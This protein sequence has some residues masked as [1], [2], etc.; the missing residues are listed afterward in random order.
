MSW[1]GLTTMNTTPSKEKTTLSSGRYQNLPDR[2]ESETVS[3][4]IFQQ[5]GFEELTEQEGSDLLRL[6]RQVEKAFY[7][8]GKALAEIRERRLYRST[9]KTFEQYCRDRFGYTRAA[10]SYK[11]AAAAVVD[12]LLT[13]GLQ[14]SGIALMPASERQLRPLVGLSPSLQSEIWQ[15]AVKTA[16]GKIP[17]GRLVKDIVQ[18]IREKTKA[19]NPYKEGEVCSILV[20]EN[21]DLRGLGGCWA[22]VVEVREFGCLVQTW[23]G[24][25]S[26]RIENLKPMDYSPR[27][28]Q[29]M[30]FL[31]A[32][33][34]KLGAAEIEEETILG[35]LALLGKIKRPFLTP[36]EEALLSC[37]EE[38]C[39]VNQEAKIVDE[40]CKH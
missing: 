9:H 36:K 21:P 34:S 8:A 12:N 13:N 14:N 33:L 23:K 37:L 32:R 24:E 25:I 5:G 22:I 3:V 30:H 35:F 28:R 31:S 7:L 10:A 29:E 38:I 20:K 16:G 11:I 15:E 19:T 39:G 27:E 17:S 6:E 2:T 40:S 4:E 1:L 18:R 26:V